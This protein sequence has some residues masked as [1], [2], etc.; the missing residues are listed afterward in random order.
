[1]YKRQ[2]LYVADGHHRTAAAARVGEECMLRNPNHRG[3]EE[4]CF[5]LAVTFPASQLRIIDYNRVV[6]DLNGMTPA[7][8]V[9]ALR[10]MCIRDR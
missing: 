5:F 9:E 2:A 1:M 3:D 7:E 4:Y 8:F 6:R 10:K